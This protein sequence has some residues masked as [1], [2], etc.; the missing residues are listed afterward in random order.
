M[1]RMNKEIQM[2]KMDKERN[3]DRV[4]KDMNK[5][6]NKGDRIFARLTMG[7]RTI[8]EFV[9]DRVENMTDLLN[10]VQRMTSGLRGLCKLY[11]R[12]QSRGWAQ[13]RPIMLCGAVASAAP[14]RMPFPWETH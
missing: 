11:V 1:D 5:K 3:I 13:E 7:A 9:I 8:V 2:E 14:T 12:N 4:N 6:I 10:E